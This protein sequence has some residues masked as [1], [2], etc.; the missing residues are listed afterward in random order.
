MKE[1]EGDEDRTF[2]CVRE[3]RERPRRIAGG[4]RRRRGKSQIN[5]AVVSK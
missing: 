1:R 5:E 2:F 3:E 4:A